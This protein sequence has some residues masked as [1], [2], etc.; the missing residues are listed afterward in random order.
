MRVGEICQFCQ[1]QDE[2]GVL[3]VSKRQSLKL[4]RM[5]ADLAE[6]LYLRSSEVDDRITNRG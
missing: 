2:G 3:S 4:V 5:I 1:L 6:A